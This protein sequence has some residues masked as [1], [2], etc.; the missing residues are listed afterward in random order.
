MLNVMIVVN[1]LV[2]NFV[3]VESFIPVLV[4]AETWWCQYPAETPARAKQWDSHIKKSHKAARAD[5][6]GP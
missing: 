4:G 5:R 6:R 1:R 2:K 3:H